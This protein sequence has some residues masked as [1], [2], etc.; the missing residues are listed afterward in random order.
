MLTRTLAGRIVLL[1]VLV[2]VASVA[3]TGIA[4]FGLFRQGAAEAARASFARD[5]DTFAASTA[6]LD[7]RRNPRQ[8]RIQSAALRQLLSSRQITL[9]EVGPDDDLAAVLT[10]PFEATDVAATR[11]YGTLSTERSTAAGSWLIEGRTN[12]TTSLLLGQGIAPAVA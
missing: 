3:V 6:G 4:T 11:Q 8:K 2:A 5:A 7:Q 10:E 9:V 12:G 1:A